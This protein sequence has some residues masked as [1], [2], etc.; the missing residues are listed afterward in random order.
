MAAGLSIRTV[1]CMTTYLPPVSITTD[2]TSAIPARARRA[3]P[4]GWSRRL[5]R[6]SD[7]KVA[8]LAD[9]EPFAQCRQADL[10]AL[11]KAADIVNVPSGTVL[12]EGSDIKHLW[13]M[14]VDGWL[15][16]SGAGNQAITVPAGWSWTARGRDTGPDTR[17][18]ALRGG[19]VLT[20]ALPELLGTLDEHPRLAE[21][22]RST[23][24]APSNV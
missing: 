24:V 6:W 14:P 10:V 11:A 7:G 1:T 4:T 15:L 8:L 9:V 17:I 5:R 12:G 13:W 20:A 23:L 18:S 2:L 22:I 3:H 16:V 19:R 21:A